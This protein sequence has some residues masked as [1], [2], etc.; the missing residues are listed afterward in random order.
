M[1]KATS[2]WEHL[3]LFYWNNNRH[4]NQFNINKRIEHLF[5][6]STFIVHKRESIRLFKEGMQLYI[7]QD[8]K[9]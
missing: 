9:K 7:H 6:K 8:T 1:K 2:N 3:L 4:Y 5:K